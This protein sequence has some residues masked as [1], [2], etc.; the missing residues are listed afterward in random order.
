MKPYQVADY[1]ALVGDSIDDIPG[2]PGIG[3]KTA[4][5]LLAK[6]DSIEGLFGDLDGVAN[7]GL[8]GAARLP[9]KLQASQEQLLVTRQ[10][11]Q[12]AC[13]LD[14]PVSDQDLCWRPPSKLELA[15]FFEAFGLEQAMTRQLQRYDW[16]ED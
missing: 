14:L 7:C 11:T 9:E 16:L 8:R 5:A 2:V 10:L 4:A 6:F 12:L 1:L 13:E 15:A 3:K